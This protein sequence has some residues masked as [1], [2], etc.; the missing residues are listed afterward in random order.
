LQT[1]IAFTTSNPSE[2]AEVRVSL[3]HYR[4]DIDGLRALAVLAVVLYHFDIGPFHGGFVGVDVFFVISG[5]L[6]TNIIQGEIDSTGFSFAKFYERR[7]RRLFPALFAMLLVVLVVGTM[8]LLPSDLIKLGNNTLAT[9]LFVSNAWYWRHS[10][11]F[12]SSSDLNPLLHTWSLAVEEQFY[13][14]LPILLLLV[15]KLARSHLKWVLLGLTLLSFLCCIVAQPLQAKATF[16][17]SPFRAWELL[18]GGWLAVGGCA[19][20]RQ[21]L[22]REIAASAALLI[23]IGSFLW[24][25]EGISFPGWVAVFPVFA[26]A[27]LLHLGNDS[28]TRIHRLLGRKPLVGIGLISYSW[29]LWH[30]PILVLAHYQNAMQPLPVM[31]RV[32]LLVLSMAVSIASFHWVETPFRRRK[33]AHPAKPVP[34]VL[35]VGL[36]ASCGLALLAFGVKQDRGWRSRVPGEV[37]ALDDARNPIIPFQRCDKKGP[38]LANANC[39]IGQQDSP[40]LALIWGDSH[41]M[42]WAPGLDVLLKQEG[43]KGVL[44]VYSTCAPLLGL[45]S[46]KTLS[47]FSKNNEVLSWLQHHPVERIYLIANWPSWTIPRQGYDLQDD[48]GRTGNYRLFAP[49]LKRTI[50]ESGP[51]AGRVILLGSE[52]GAPDQVPLRLAMHRWKGLPM[53]KS[54]TRSEV[55]EFTRWFWTAADPM[56]GTPRL[57]LVDPTSWFCDAHNCSFMG[58]DGTLLYRDSHHLSVAGARFVASRLMTESNRIDML[59]KDKR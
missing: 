8:L 14:G 21:G 10:G 12:D 20:V 44:A 22:T 28:G 55:H 30:F 56:A 1:G 11:Y 5:Y 33:R 36:A 40:R 50:S 57:Q 24:V 4:R 25:P 32:G 23:L 6:I 38:D 46:S 52:P 31:V 18:I 9:L 59:S 37:A 43:L 27:S 34:S 26:T 3:V 45:H 58:K 51:F 42:A 48:E 7:V 53:P 35:M 15:A 17:L 13:I 16:F 19:S 39:I 29:Y 41:A 2:K 47:C 49:A 54:I